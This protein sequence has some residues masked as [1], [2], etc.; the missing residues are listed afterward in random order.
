MIDVLLSIPI[1]SYVFFPTAGASLSTSVNIIFFYMTWS[2]L[3]FSHH[4]LEIHLSGLLVLRVIFW[5]VPSLIF[6][7]FDVGLPSLAVGFKHGG[8]SSLPPRNARKLAKT[9]GLATLNVF[10]LLAVEAAVSMAYSL[11]SK[12]HIFKMSTT[13]PLPWTV[14]KHVTL[15]LVSREVLMYYL[16]RRVLHGNNSALAKMHMA[17]AHDKPGA[18]YSLQVYTDH[19]LA[20][21]VHRFLPV[22]LPSVLIRTH[23]LTYFIVIIITTIEETL[24]MSG[25][26]FIPGIVMSG[27]TA[28]T[29]IHYAGKGSS[30]F[31]ALGVMDWGHG[32]SKGR[33]VLEDVRKE[34]DKHHVQERSAKKVDE[35]SNVV[36]GG[37]DS[38]R[39]RVK[40][41]K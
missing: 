11:V 2:S 29:A 40:S 31:G 4:A 1:L 33:D 8:R 9:M 27:I 19:P 35:G 6:L 23:M 10:V 12:R 36:K 24:A 30:N 25:Y 5:L 34:A 7:L 18:P 41:S 3:V 17:Y 16:H 28:R 26:T 13:L 15:I 21:L 38:L 32:T 14:T 22:Y 20:L 37:M 39:K